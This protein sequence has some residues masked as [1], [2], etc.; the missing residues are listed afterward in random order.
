MSNHDLTIST[1]N[2]L[3]QISNDGV[4][5]FTESAE[6]V[7]D[8]ELK[9]LFVRRS[10]E[11]AASLAELQG[12]VVSLGGK[13]VDS[14]T[15]GGALHRI[16]IDLKTAITS[17]DNLAVLNEVERGEDVA[18]RAF[19]KAAEQENLLPHI[20]SVLLRQLAGAQRNHDEIKKL[21]DSARAEAVH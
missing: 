2:D 13:P 18:I 5:G 4:K 6:H 21:R 3:I 20:R 10:Q 8:P 7:Q 12:L 15:V 14:S 9:S 19:S 16:W 1:L 11:V 17:D